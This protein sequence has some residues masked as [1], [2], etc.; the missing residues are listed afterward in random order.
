[1]SSKTTTYEFKTEIKQLLNIIVHSLYSNREIFLRELI[2]NASDA[3]DKLRF[4]LQ[5]EPGLLDKDTEFKIK[6]IC[7]REKKMLTVSDNGIGMTREELIENLGTIAKSGTSAFL[8]ALEQSKSQNGISPEL[9]GQFGVGFYSAFMVA[10]RVTVVTRSPGEKTGVR[11]EST[12]EGEFSI[13]ECEKPGHGT[14]VILHLKKPGEDEEDYTDEWVIRR[15][16]RQHSDFVR[17]PIVMD[18]EREEPEKDADGKPIEGKTK[19]IVKEETLNSMK[20]IWTK[21]KNEITDDEYKDFY[22]HISHDWNPPLT[23]THFTMEGITEYTA[24]LYIPEKAPFDLFY[25]ER[26]HGLQLYSRRVF[27]MDN[28]K[29]LLPEYLR[30]VR[31]VVDAPD[32]N[33]N[34]SR[35][36][37]QQDAIVRNIRKNL[38]K[39]IIETLEKMSDEMYGKFYDQFGALIKE[40]VYTDFENKDRLLPLLRYKT[41]NSPDKWRSLSDYVANMKPDQKEIYYITA[42]TLEMAKNSPH[43]EL[44]RDKG[45]EVLLMTDPIDEFVLQTLTEFEGKT[46]KSA[47]KGDLEI[48]KEKKEE[49]KDFSGLFSKIR[50]YLQDDIKE[51][52]ASSHLKNSLSCLSGDAQD[53]SAYMEKLMKATGQPIPKTKRILELN[54]DHPV[55]SMLLDRYEKNNDD[56]AIADYSRLLYDLALIAEGG[57][58]ENPAAFNK[59]VGDIMTEA[60]CTR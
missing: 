6:L 39:K 44:L 25:P 34:I 43:I 30:F 35:E 7:D 48:E 22:N 58:I 49:N 57:K 60:I 59:I 9:I 5:T 42:E 29:E 15:I 17:Y 56:P 24:I 45:Y 33:L 23:W 28:C 1:M 40:G 12:G 52:K 20:A 31:G 32:L 13:E 3:I 27:I 47:E 18:V 51:V 4:R 16:V 36:I 21:K 46:F 37:L 41:T 2:S 55:I 50:V 19:K 53:M 10:D 8:K 14:D 11:W 38:V 26:K 54:T